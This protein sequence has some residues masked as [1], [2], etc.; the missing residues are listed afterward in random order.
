MSSSVS[1]NNYKRNW[2]HSKERK[3]IPS[4]SKTTR[5][6]YGVSADDEVSSRTHVPTAFFNSPSDFGLKAP[7]FGTSCTVYTKARTTNIVHRLGLLVSHSQILVELLVECGGYTD[8]LA[9]TCI[10][11]NS[12]KM[13]TFVLGVLVGSV[14]AIDNGLGRSPPMV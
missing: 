12:R 11:R 2:C 3:F 10:T 1:A 14:A 5:L 6:G 7:E 9:A 8:W 4:K 13:K